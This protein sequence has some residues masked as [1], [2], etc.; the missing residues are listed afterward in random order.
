MTCAF[1]GCDRPVEARGWCKKHYE[2][3][4][5]HGDVNHVRPPRPKRE[6]PCSVDGCDRPMKSRGW[7]DKHYAR[8][9]KHGD[10]LK[11]LPHSGG[12]K[13]GRRKKPVPCSMDGCDRPARARGWCGTHHNRWLKHG[14]P[15]I[16]LPR[17]GG[18]P[19]RKWKRKAK[20]K[21]PAAV[22]IGPRVS[23]EK[24]NAPWTAEELAETERE[25]VEMAKSREPER[26]PPFSPLLDADGEPLPWRCVNGRCEWPA[27]PGK[28]RCERCQRAW[29]ERDKGDVID[30]RRE[31]KRPVRTP[32]SERGP[33]LV[34]GCDM[35]RLDDDL[36]CHMHAADGVGP[37][38]WMSPAVPW[39]RQDELTALHRSRHPRAWGER[40]WDPKTGGKLCSVDGCERP[41]KARGWCAMHHQRWLKH[42]DPET[43]VKRGRPEKHARGC[44]VDGC[45]GKHAGKGYC[46]RHYNRWLRHGDP[47]GGSPPRAPRKPCSVKGCDRP[48]K[49]KGW[50]ARHHNRWL[51][52]GD[53]FA[54]VPIVHGGRRLFSMNKQGECSVDGCGKV[55][56]LRKGM[57]DS[58][59]RRDLRERQRRELVDKVKA[60]QAPKT[61]PAEE[62]MNRLSDVRDGEA[63]VVL[64]EVDGDELV[65]T[66]E[67]CRRVPAAKLAELL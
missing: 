15:N 41:V 22:P 21:Q 25:H 17:G 47:L 40:K 2:R 26:P 46:K 65:V 19:G 48:A 37:R 34:D 4:R 9:H 6:G 53:V 42:G 23:V 30:G 67:V 3:W 50:C 61:D 12:A 58:H 36:V 51:Q 18:R 10:P 31:A 43:R 60:E 13:P 63:R 55:G 54:D 62:Q 1:E 52:H 35:H 11:V 39:K 16:V 66:L 7:C 27:L 45:E 14:D 24:M 59:Y 57:C 56:T 38:T 20:P 32:A 33:C 49:A 29:D 8:W 44:K 28:D 5:K 64:V